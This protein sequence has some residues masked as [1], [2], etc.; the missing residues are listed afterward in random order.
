MQQIYPSSF[1]KGLVAS[2]VATLIYQSIPTVVF[3]QR[4]VQSPYYRVGK[5]FLKKVL[6][7]T[8]AETSPIRDLL[9]RS[10]WISTYYSS[11]NG[12]LH[13][14]A[15]GLR[16]G[17]SGAMSSF[18]TADR[19]LQCTNLVNN[20]LQGFSFDFIRTHTR[21][22]SKPISVV[23][24]SACAGLVSNSPV[25]SDQWSCKNCLKVRYPSKQKGS[26]GSSSADA[27]S[28]LRIAAEFFVFGLLT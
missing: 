19:E 27:L 2:S 21:V 4:S 9:T 16:G 5:Y 28:K 26:F 25:D 10:A 18:I 1:V 22:L 8:K 20:I 3:L 11:C 6:T 15:P 7:R 13:N 12:L 14:I 24:A 17:L 23:L